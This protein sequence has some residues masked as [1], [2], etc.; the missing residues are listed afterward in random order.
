[1]AATITTS[2]EAG[3]AIITALESAW[4]HLR[5]DH[6][7]LPRVVFITG[8]GVKANGVVL[9]HYHHNAW[10]NQLNESDLPEIFVSTESMIL[11]AE[12]VMIT[13]RHEAAHA[14][15]KVRGI[16]DTNPLTGYHRKDY[17]KLA[18]E[19]GLKCTK[20]PH[21]GWSETVLT[22]ETKAYDSLIMLDLEASLTTMRKGGVMVSKTKGAN[23]KTKVSVT[24]VDATGAPIKPKNKN[25]VV[26]TCGCESPAPIRMAPTKFRKHP[27]IIC[28][29]CE[30][31]CSPRD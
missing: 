2:T 12:D 4:N 19:M 31:L 3:S 1:M 17:A 15:A 14:L 26:L 20:V 30:E 13:L 9:G 23:G 7:E 5:N 21:I 25:Y 8:T 16:Q 27:G 6:P 11:G 22:E 24:K 29:G 18:T 28:V 10:F